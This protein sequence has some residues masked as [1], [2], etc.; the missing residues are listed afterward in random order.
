MI[1]ALL[2]Q[3]L[4]YE[5]SRLNEVHLAWATQLGAPSE[6]LFDSISELMDFLAR[7]DQAVA[8]CG[9]TGLSDYLSLVREIVQTSVLAISDPDQCTPEYARRLETLGGWINQARDYLQAPGDASTVASMAALLLEEPGAIDSPT[10]QSAVSKLLTPTLTSDSNPTHAGGSHHPF[11][12]DFSLS[13]A[14]IDPNQLAAFLAEAPYQNAQLE[15]AVVAWSQGT[16]SQAMVQDAQRSVH[17]L[18]GSGYILGL[19]GIGKLAH[20]LE[21]ILEIVMLG[22]SSAQAPNTSLVS[23]VMDAVFCLQQMVGYLQGT[24]E[25]PV[26]AEG[27]TRRLLGWI[28]W[29][30][31]QTE[32]SPIMP[33][34]DTK[35]DAVAAE[36]LPPAPSA[37]STPGKQGLLIGSDQLDKLL[38]R[39]GQFV[40]HNDRTT[41]LARETEAWL[42]EIEKTN[43]LLIQGCQQLKLLA[44]SQQL[45]SSVRVDGSEDFD[46]LELERFNAVQNMV[47]ALDEKV[48]DNTL[49]LNRARSV[50]D[51]SANLLREDRYALV[52]QRQKLIALRTAEVSTIVSRL[53][54]TVH[55]TAIAA[56]RRVSLEITGE[57]VRMDQDALQRLAEPLL[58]LLRNA[59]DH[60]IEPTDERRLADK[61]ET[62]SIQVN[63]ARDGQ[64][65]SIRIIDDGR[66][67]DLEAISRKAVS[68]GMLAAD[69]MPTEAQLLR[70]ILQPGFSTRDTVTATSGR[71]MGLDIV[72]DRILQLSGQ[73]NVRSVAGLGCEITLL[74]PAVSGARHAL[75]IRCSGNVYA[76]PSQNIQT[77]LPAGAAELTP[78]AQGLELQHEGQSFKLQALSDWLNLHKSDALELRTYAQHST[79]IVLRGVGESTALLVDAALN[80]YELMVQEVGQLV[81]CLGGLQGAAVMA[82]GS[83]VL[84]LDLP[85]LARTASEPG[86]LRP[87]GVAAIVKPPPC[88][89]VVEDSWTSRLALKQLLEDTG[90]RV[91]TAS[92]GIVAL[93]NI[94]KSV[95]D[96]V[97][98]DLEMPHL[99]GLEL[100]VRLRAYPPWADLPL[101][102][103]TSRSAEKHKAQAVEAGVSCYLTKP[104][105]DEDLLACVRELLR[106]HAKETD[107]AETILKEASA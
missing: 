105:Q 89:L 20:C 13:T 93:E 62:G 107:Q 7:F 10:V 8:S 99:N 11:D 43:Q 48:H 67:L 79:I 24:D 32:A 36:N 88:V 72:N 44:G 90:F 16:A 102:M 3:E 6:A 100:T 82:D 84:L 83:S 42:K 92:D 58:H 37:K 5:R 47:H 106:T 98:T 4:E 39:S 101:L 12:A 25:T 70:L 14:N 46:P 80:F 31:T 26:G 18:K 103:L 86:R 77:I 2:L 23:D 52:S 53:K 38:R 74:L 56:D 17:T 78:F 45:E 66:G 63:F 1:L 34:P 65:V 87:A 96:L 35:F 22:A 19:Q 73:I 91:V 55:Q 30:E 94:R 61:P 97:I 28:H 50:V 41:Q 59:V 71:G 49:L 57:D 60:G 76:L 69:A 27:I 85:A 95:P 54:R 40:I 29:V 104:Y 21:D 9:L 81:R 33:A 51:Q 75:L 64:N 68:L 15:A